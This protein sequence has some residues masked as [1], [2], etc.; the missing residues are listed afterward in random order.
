MNNQVR[1]IKVSYN[2]A[3]CKVRIVVEGSTQLELSEAEARDL[4]FKLS[5][6]V[7]VIPVGRHER[8]S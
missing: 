2:G 6:T 7:G 1:D 4:A 3:L 8:Q 5:A